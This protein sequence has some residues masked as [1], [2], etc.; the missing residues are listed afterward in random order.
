MKSNIC[1]NSNLRVCTGCG[2]CASICGTK[3]ITI[4]LDVEGYYKPIVDEQKC[5]ECG[6]CK[7]S[8]YKYDESLLQI[9]K[10]VVCY[11]AVNKNANQLKSSSSGG[12]SRLLMEE[13]IARGYKVF[14]CAYNTEENIA[15]S[16]VASTMEE[17]DLFYG[18]KYFQSYT[19]EGFEE[20]TKDR[21]NQKYAIFGTPCQIYAFSQTTK[22][23][24]TPEKYLL[25]DVFCHGCPSMKLWKSYLA[26]TNKIT[27]CTKYDKVA[28]RSKSYGWHEYCFD[29]FNKG[30]QYT[31]KKINDPFYEMFFSMDIMNEACYDCNS[32]SSMAYGDIRLGDY[33]GS[34]YDMDMKGVS[35]V[36]AK[37]P[38]GLEYFN[39]IKEKLSVEDADLDHI[40]VGQSYGKP[41]TCNKIRRDFLLNNLFEDCD[42][43]TVLSKYQ[44]M[45]PIKV[46]VKKFL[47]AI[48][49][50]CPKSVYFPIKKVLHSI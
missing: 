43:S 32:R 20:I 35:A 39:A 40:L 15:K 25:V 5:V 27:N 38:L 1:D 26:H 44:K 42:I 13:C 7:K 41:H 17:L 30:K 16:V 50:R 28:F 9:D 46:R 14:G 6:L 48:I 49:K 29:F 45:F 3:A 11:A 10:V 4:Q 33:W 24:R 12:I 37:T 34:K 22:Y 47:K 36:V 8:C 21:T 18:S 23:K 31:C 19:V 2:I